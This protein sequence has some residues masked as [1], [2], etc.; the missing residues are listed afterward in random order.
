MEYGGYVAPPSH[1]SK[2]GKKKIPDGRP[3]ELR[4]VPDCD[5]SLFRYSQLALPLLLLIII[6]ASVCIGLSFWQGPYGWIRG[7]NGARNGIPRDF[8]LDDKSYTEA[9]LNRQL[10]GLRAANFV[11]GMGPLILVVLAL[12]A[13]LRPTFL[14]AI[15]LLCAFFFFSLG[16]MSSVSFALGIDQVNWI[17]DCPNKLTFNPSNLA[18][19]PA[20]SPS[21]IVGPPANSNGVLPSR[22]ASCRSRIQITSA[23]IV[24]DAAQA[25]AAFILS[26]LLVYTTME[27]NWAWGPGDIPVEESANQPRAKFPPPSPFT[28]IAETR[29][30][31]VWM[32]IAATFAFVSIAFILMLKLHELRIKVK[33]VDSRNDIIVSAGWPMTNNRFRVS[34][35]GFCIAACVFSLIDSYIFRRRFISYLL[36]GGLFW[37]LVG[38]LVIFSMDVMQVGEA[39]NMTCTG[40][41]TAVPVKCVYFPYYGTCWMD[42]CTATLIT[43]YLIYE[44]LYR[45]NATYDTYYFFADSEWLRNH[46]L[47]VEQTDREAFDWKKYTMDTGKEYY[48]SASLGISTC[49]RPKNYIEPEGYVE[50]QAPSFVAPVYQTYA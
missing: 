3:A 18:Q 35:S 34:I 26:V 38:Y 22:L 17:K 42:W 25:M 28:H 37:I 27:S 2:L 11:T 12:R 15:L 49:M 7:R 16:C 29:R 8:E 6:S 46:S 9:G 5:Y 13:G 33:T 43:I 48:Y 1:L 41:S 44:F 32:T 30:V 47:F 19:V 10:K 4:T 45:V 14:R 20:F 31:Y 50:Q 23:A 36:A 39:K 21:D 24:A 40:G